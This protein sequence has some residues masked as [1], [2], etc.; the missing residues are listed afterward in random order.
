[1]VN[2][3]LQAQDALVPMSFIFRIKNV[4]CAGDTGIFSYYLEPIAQFCVIG[5]EDWFFVKAKLDAIELKSFS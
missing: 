4:V 3:R 1:M 5:S 2:A